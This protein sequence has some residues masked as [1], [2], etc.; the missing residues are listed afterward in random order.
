MDDNDFNS[1]SLQELLKQNFNLSADIAV[2][3]LDALEKVRQRSLENQYTSSHI[4]ASGNYR[5]IFMDC[6]MPVMDGFE[7]THAIRMILPKEVCTIVALSAMTHQH[8][9]YKAKK[10]GMDEFRKEIV[11]ILTLCVYSCKTTLVSED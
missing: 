2:H 11:S 4:G 3:G 8:E 6:M 7:A 5:L 10:S 9:A 1:F